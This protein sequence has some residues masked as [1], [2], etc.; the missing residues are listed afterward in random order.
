MTGRAARD[1]GLGALLTVALAALAIALPWFGA[2]RYVQTLVYYLAYDIVLGQSWNLMSGM[3]GYVSFAH[4]ALAG[5]GAYAAVIALNAGWPVAAALG[6]GCLTAIAASAIVGASSLRL[7]G[8][9]FTFATLF[10]Q[11]LARLIL[12]KL[13]F[14]GGPGGLAL[15]DILPLALPQ[16]LMVAL[17]ALATIG[18][19]ALRRSRLGIRLLAIRADEDAAASLG[20][21]VTRLKLG[22]F[23]ASAAI[24]GLGGA[25]HGLF[26]ASLYPDD[27]FSVDVSLT[28]LAVP[29]IGGMATASG[30]VA[31]AALLVGLGE[32]L[33][34]FAP[35]LHLVVI[36]ALLL[37]VVL[38]MPRGLMPF[39]GG[40][41][42]RLRPAPPAVVAASRSAAP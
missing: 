35:S 27:V 36:G 11:E 31:A 41:A 14:S 24:A 4:G 19:L 10:F 32:L 29:M 7:R 40:I 33:Q 18:V 42:R 15:Q 21:G 13:P 37:A 16:V 1:L 25:V 38:F 28:A 20:I 17:A 34:I 22:V 39:L 9:A 3:T 8:V 30:P 12:R 26:T 23:C 5:L 6:A 2:S